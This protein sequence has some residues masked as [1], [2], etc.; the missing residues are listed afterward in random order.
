VYYFLQL[1]ILYVLSI[2]YNAVIRITSIILVRYEI[3]SKSQTNSCGML[4]KKFRFPQIR[5]FLSF[6]YKRY[7]SRGTKNNKIRTE[8]SQLGAIYQKIGLPLSCCVA[9]SWTFQRVTWPHDTPQHVANLN[10]LCLSSYS[11]FPILYFVMPYYG[12]NFFYSM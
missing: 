5:S 12:S 10:T 4:K 6:F 2:S 8:D 1:F 9:F 3:N 7:C 11:I